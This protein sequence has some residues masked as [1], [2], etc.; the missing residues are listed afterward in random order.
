ML[1]LER[2]Q[3]QPAPLHPPLRTIA[4]PSSCA[5]VFPCYALAGYNLPL[6]ER[7]I[8]A[9]HVER[10]LGSCIGFNHAGAHERPRAALRTSLFRHPR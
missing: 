1:L 7:Q 10:F 2:V 5:A 4:L 6:F 3:L 8:G 9:S